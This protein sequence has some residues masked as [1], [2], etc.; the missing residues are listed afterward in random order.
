MEHEEAS[1]GTAPTVEEFEEYG[2]IG[3]SPQRSDVEDKV[4]GSAVYLEDMKFSGMLFGKVLRS[5]YSHARILSVDTSKAEKLPGVR[6]IVTGEEFPFL[7]GESFWDEPFLAKDRVRY[8]GEAVAAIAAEDEATAEQAKHLITVEYEELPAVFDVV[9]AAGPEAPLIHEN[10]ET[11]HHA[12]GVTPIKGTNVCNHFELRKGDVEKGFADSDYIFEDTFTTPMQ[13]H[14]T[15]EP[16]GTICRI[17]DENKITLWTN[18][19]SPYR[20][21]E[22]SRLSRPLERGHVRGDRL[23]ATEGGL[24]PPADLLASPALRTVR[25]VRVSRRGLRRGVAEQLANDGEPQVGGADARKVVAQIVQPHVLEPR[26]HADCPPRL[27]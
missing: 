2:I 14:C 1:V 6:G 7:H 23:A 12:P 25:Q 9:E 5:Q 22:S 17:T 19:G 21:L 11:Y 18:N 4:R 16:H 20:C 3:K 13:Q 15:L 8:K 24:D 27:L 10:I 26:L